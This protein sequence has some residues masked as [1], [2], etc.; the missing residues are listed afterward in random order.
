M[1]QAMC[2]LLRLNKST[3]VALCMLLRAA[4]ICDNTTVRSSH[5][6]HTLLGWLILIKFLSL[7]TSPRSTVKA[8]SKSS[9]F[10]ESIVYSICHLLI[11]TLVTDLLSGRWHLSSLGSTCLT[12][13][14]LFSHISVF[15]MNKCLHLFHFQAKP[16]Y[17]FNPVVCCNACFFHC[18]Y[19]VGLS[20]TLSPASD[21]KSGTFPTT[22]SVLNTF[23]VHFSSQE[24]Y[25]SFKMI[26]TETERI[27]VTSVK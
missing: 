20:T 19:L 21:E 3:I 25:V 27:M 1:K 22:Q 16:I 18:F 10:S 8:G 9:L 14:Q 24:R 2:T 11:R 6:K 13:Q 5:L 23:C 17:L 26:S 15:S 7:F 12:S 4:V